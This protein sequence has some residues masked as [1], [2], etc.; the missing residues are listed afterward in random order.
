MKPPSRLQLRIPIAASCLTGTDNRYHRSFEHFAQVHILLPQ[1]LMS[2]SCMRSRILA[3][4]RSQTTSLC[5]IFPRSYK[6]YTSPT[7]HSKWKTPTNVIAKQ[8]MPN[9]KADPLNTGL[10]AIPDDS[11]HS[12]PRYADVSILET[13]RQD[14]L[15]LT[16]SQIDWH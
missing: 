16:I 14:G 15:R 5:V 10:S 6:Y 9:A 13:F 2:G 3:C 7:A 8:T 4:S 1:N 11:P 12:Q